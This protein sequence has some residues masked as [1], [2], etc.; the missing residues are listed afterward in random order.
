MA[1][2]HTAERPKPPLPKA[3]YKLV[4]PLL[5]AVLRSPLHALMSGSLMTL[6][7]TGRKSGRRYAIPV[8]Y[9]QR[10]Q[11]LFVFSHSAWANNFRQPAAVTLRLRGREVRGTAQ[12]IHDRERVPEIVSM[13]VAKQGEAM[14]QRMGLTGT[15][16]GTT[17]IE[18]ALAEPAP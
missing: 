18:I 13:F 1:T 8:G 5:M 2:D 6:R 9:L 14:A 10:G 17:F 11:Q 12:V 7:F 16:A 3:A 4:N 15:A